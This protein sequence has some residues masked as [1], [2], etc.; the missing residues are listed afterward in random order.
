M[1]SIRSSPQ[2]SERQAYFAGGSEHSGQQILGRG[3]RKNEQDFGNSTEGGDALA[4]AFRRA[5]SRYNMKVLIKCSDLLKI[6]YCYEGKV[7]ALS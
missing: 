6:I 3:K 1:D 2:D 7:S 5:S 4:A